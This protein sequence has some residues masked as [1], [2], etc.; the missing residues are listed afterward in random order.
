MRILKISIIVA[1]IFII[2]IVIIFITNCCNNQKI[3][4]D[5]TVNI[6]GNSLGNMNNGGT[7]AGQGN[8]TY[9]V[10]DNKESIISILTPYFPFISDYRLFEISDDSSKAIKLNNFMTG[11]NISVV[12]NKIFYTG[13]NNIREISGFTYSYNINTGK[14]TEISS[15]DGI[16]YCVANNFIYS[17]GSDADC[18]IKKYIIY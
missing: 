16:D 2:L 15:I 10:C 6:I 17:D 18:N 7:I 12:G 4:Q 8:I 11:S 1:S 9:C 5:K 3:I 14:S 13:L